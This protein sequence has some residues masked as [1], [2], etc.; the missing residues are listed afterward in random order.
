MKPRLRSFKPTPACSERAAPSP[1]Q[2]QSG[3]ISRLILRMAL[4]IAATGAILFV[5]AGTVRWLG[6][7]AYLIETGAL[8]LAA[9]LWLAKYDPELLRERLASPIQREQRAWDKMLVATLMFLGLG[10]LVLMALDAER[11]E[12]SHVPGG[13]Q[14]IG[15][16]LILLSFYVGFLTIRENS[17]AAQTVKIQ[18]ERGQEVIS[19]GPYRY[20]RHPMYASVALFTLGAPLLLGSWYGLALCPLVIAVLGSRA[21][22]EERVLAAELDG[23]SEYSDRVQHRLI[24]LVW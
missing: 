7:W 12:W 6:A 19:T 22:M 13:V 11:N 24:P 1:P 2:T 18:K 3:A 17:Y 20:V 10:W 15:F 5:S 4:S 8:A 21:M 9:G 16:G 23:Y 14:V